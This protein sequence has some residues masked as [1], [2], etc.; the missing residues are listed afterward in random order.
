M[1]ILLVVYDNDSYMN[2]FPQG[3]AYIA[4]VLIRKGYK[5][6]IYNQDKFHYPDE[7]LTNYLDINKFDVVGV[8][9]IAGYYQY[10]KL[11]KISEAINK[12][13]NRP[14]YV[15]G[16]H[17][18]SPEPE[19]FIKKTKADTVVMGEGE[20][21]IVELMETLASNGSLDRVDGIAYSDGEKVKINKRRQLIKDIDTIPFPAY[22]QFP[23]DFYRL[24]RTPYSNN[25][26]FV[27]P[28]LSGRGCTFECTFCY[29]LDAGF[30]PRSNESIIEEI[31]LLIKDYQI[32]GF[33]F[34]D[35]L[36]MSSV[37]RTSSLCEDII[38]ADLNI[39]WS[40]NGRLNYAKK[41][42]LKLMKRA[43]CVFVNYGIEAMD[44]QVLKNMKKGLTT[45]QIVKGV[46]ATLDAKISPGLNIIFG[47]LGDNKETLNKGVEFLLKYSDCSQLR[48]IRP[49]TAYPGS[50]LYYYAIEKELLK[51]CEDF[52]E[53]KHINSDLVAINFTDLSDEEFH[54]CLLDANKR[55]LTHFYQNKL[56]DA[57][58]EAER[59][60]LKK[61]TNFRGFR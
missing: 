5:V 46:E 59:L 54:H 30:R 42:L 56:A 1:K 48:T 2:W 51:D 53:N 57:I 26:E 61:D 25:N 20:L 22:E 27:M 24:L 43:G 31:K 29:R 10:K 17:G 55:L 40:C 21:T 13:K 32:K 9:V 60:Y 39:K 47:N 4:A 23:M 36:L 44:D 11:L 3:L 41:D 12:S 7:H 33:I 35:E 58:N 52:Y 15:I 45:E 19:F 28:I 18:P 49:V 38:S 37:K 16:G 8:G 50:P 6:T 14:F 34:S